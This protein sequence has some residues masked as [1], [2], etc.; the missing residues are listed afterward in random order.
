M[1]KYAFAFLFVLSVFA[2]NASETLAQE[3]YVYDG[4]TFSVMLTS[5]SANTQIVSVQFSHNGQWVDFKITDFESLE[6][7]ADGGYAYTVLDGKN[8]EFVVDYYRIQDY[9]KVH[10]YDTG[11]EWTLYRRK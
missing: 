11:E 8:Q 10:N 1:K 7:D 3:Y 5:N 6:D 9:V 4:K 2:F